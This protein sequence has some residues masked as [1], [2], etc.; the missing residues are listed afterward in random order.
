VSLKSSPGVAIRVWWLPPINK[1]PL[2][3]SHRLIKAVARANTWMEGSY[4]ERSHHWKAWHPKL[5]LQNATSTERFEALSS[6]RTLQKGS[7]VAYRHPT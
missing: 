5:D 3:A 1:L 7:S 6:R 4:L 2:D